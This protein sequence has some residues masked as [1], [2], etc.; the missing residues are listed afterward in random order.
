L[1]GAVLLR[2]LI[3][4]GEA[5]QQQH[6]EEQQQQQQQQ[7]EEQ[8]QQQQ[9]VD[10]GRLAATTGSLQTTFLLIFI[11]VIVVSNFLSS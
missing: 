6:Q 8:Q 4:C 7:H 9:L 10:V 1:K 5:Q 11:S 3:E 2:A